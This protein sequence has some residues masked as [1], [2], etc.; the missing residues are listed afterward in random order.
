MSFSLTLSSTDN[1][2]Y[3][4]S[5]SSLGLQSPSGSVSPVSGRSRSTSPVMG[6]E[7]I[8]DAG[9]RKDDAEG[10]SDGSSEPVCSFALETAPMPAKSTFNCLYF[11]A[12]ICQPD[13]SPPIASPKM[14][15]G[16]TTKVSVNDDPVTTAKASIIL[17]ETPT[18][19]SSN[20]DETDKND[21]LLMSPFLI[22][23]VDASATA[24]TLPE[25]A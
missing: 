22:A 21:L 23:G 17:L 9:T 2:E 4:A 20:T 7:V 14:E 13:E 19:F 10:G 12:N 8:C 11:V 15:P 25:D 16:S 18:N 5:G 24:P 1:L 3:D 6:P